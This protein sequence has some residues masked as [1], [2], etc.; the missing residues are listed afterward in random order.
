ML[1][2]SERQNPLV[3]RHCDLQLVT[4]LFVPFVFLFCF[5]L[6]SGL[7]QLGTHSVDYFCSHYNI[8]DFH[9]LLREIT[10]ARHYKSPWM[11]SIRG[12]CKGSNLSLDGTEARRRCEKRLRVI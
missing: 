10:R 12:G 8:H 9:L 11:D 3:E 2:S 5:L 7:C 1:P 4:S 6:A